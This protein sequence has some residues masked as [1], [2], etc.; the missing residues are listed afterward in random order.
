MQSTN[1]TT[2]KEIKKYNHI[3]KNI[4]TEIDQNLSI[5]SA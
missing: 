3:Y 2:G 4:Y 1:D 5:T